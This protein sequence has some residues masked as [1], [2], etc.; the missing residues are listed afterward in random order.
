[1]TRVFILSPA[2]SGGERARLIAN[3]RA[4][5]ELAH[6]LQRGEKVALG[7]IFS[8]LSGLYFRGKFAYAKKFGRPP[9]R[10]AGSYVITSNRGLIPA[11]EAISLKTLESF[12]TTE[13]DPDEAGYRRPLERDARRL[14][15]LLAEDSQVVLLGSIGTNKYAEILIAHFGERLLFPS[16]F[17]GRGDMSRGGLLLRAVAEDRELD[18]LPVL[19]AVRRGK[20]P[21]KLPPRS[22][23]YKITEGTLVST[24]Q[25]RPK[26]RGR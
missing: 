5:F 16:S 13:I 18:Y 4:R 24:Q 15:K 19:G 26:S 2:N 23:G 9:E 22:W 20:R 12:A 11:N 10:A 8:F 17:V 6:R 14:G 1:V 25:D 3:P 21:E 7:E